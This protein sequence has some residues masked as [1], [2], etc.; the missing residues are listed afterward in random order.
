[1]LPEDK[2]CLIHLSINS[3]QPRPDTEQVLIKESLN[4]WR[5][6]AG[7]KM[8]LGYVLEIANYLLP[9]WKCV[10]GSILGTV[11]AVVHKMGYI[12]GLGGA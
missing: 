6:K 7:P 3:I 10:W 1:M 2:V 8:G 11:I 12:S 9:Q 4:S 5:D